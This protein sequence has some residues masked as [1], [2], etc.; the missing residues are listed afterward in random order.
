[1]RKL[2]TLA[3]VAALGS[4]GWISAASAELT[5]TRKVIAIIGGDLYLGTAVGNLRGAGVLNVQSQINP[6]IICKGEFTSSKEL[7]GAGELRCSD[8]AVSAFKFTRIDVFHGHG[9]G[10][11]SRGTMSF[12][13]GMTLAES[14]PYLVLPVG[15][16]FAAQT[17]VLALVDE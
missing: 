9:T 13:Y 8:G 7:G 17:E 4:A 16:K 2:L 10:K 3:M 14:V 11:F 1:M 5:A 15:K 12:T 6:R